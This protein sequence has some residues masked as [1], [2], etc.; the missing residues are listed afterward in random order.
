MSQKLC[1]IIPCYNEEKRLDRKAF[2]H[3]FKQ[4]PEVAFL[5]VNDGSKDK[6]L[7]LL[8]ELAGSF[9]QVS[10]LDLAQNAGKAQAVRAGVLQAVEQGHTHVGYLDADLATPLQEIGHLMN[11]LLS[12]K[13]FKMVMGSRLKRLGAQ[14]ERKFS[15]HLLGRVFATFASLSLDLKVYDTQCGAKLFESTV[16]GEIFKQPFLSYWIF[17][18]ELLFR[19]KLTQE[20]ARNPDCILELPLNVWQDKAGSKLRAFDFFKAP[21]ELLQML[22]RYRF[23]RSQELPDWKL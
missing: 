10:Y 5:F 4:H 6:T 3:Y 21:W 16:A 8:Q 12:K 9:S 23:F 18:V 11:G 13:Q 1:L 2:E 19:L 20:F 22:F 17:D 7:P 15:R 14:I